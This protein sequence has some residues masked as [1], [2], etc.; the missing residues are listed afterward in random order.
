MNSS[1]INW[2]KCRI[3]SDPKS[4][5]VVYRQES[6]VSAPLSCRDRG[7]DTFIKVKP[8]NVTHM[9]GQ[10]SSDDVHYRHIIFT[11][12][13]PYSAAFMWILYYLNIIMTSFE[14]G[15]KDITLLFIYGNFICTKWP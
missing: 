4:W 15:K 3:R 1:G 5:L 9:F 7:R 8:A 13:V 10:V 14:D 12:L 2:S 11:F 6:V